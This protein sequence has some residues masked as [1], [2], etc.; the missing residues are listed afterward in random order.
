MKNLCN[1]L[2]MFLFFV[3]TVSAQSPQ[4]MNYQAVV[5]NTSGNPVANN[6][7]VKLRFTIHDGSDTGPSVFTETQSTTANQF[8]LVNVK[9]GA[10]GS[11]SGVNWG[12][13]S[14]FLEV[15]VE[16][17]N[18]GTFNSMGNSQLL[19]VPYA[20]YAANSNAGATGAQGP[21]GPQGDAG[22]TGLQGD[23]GPT[24]PTGPDGNPG[25]T[26]AE[27]PIG[28][29]GAGVTGPQGDV[30]ATGAEGP[31]GPIGNTGPAGDQGPTGLQGNTGAQGDAGPTGPTGAGGGA[32]GATGETGATG[33]TGNTGPQGLTGPT[34]AGNTGPTGPQ[35]ATG[36]A[37]SGTLSVFQSAVTAASSTT[38]TSASPVTKTSLALAAGTYIVTFSADINSSCSANCGTFVFDDGTTTFS[39]GSV[40]NNGGYLP[41]SH[42]AYVTYNAAATLNIK[43]YSFSASYTT[44]IRN[45][46]IIA[47]KVQ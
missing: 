4:L 7:P 13:G 42:T 47:V 23:A 38:N 33:P 11:L 46:R 12:N 31:T 40:G 20:L 36:A 41:I 1:T 32:T 8:G 37:G 3:V 43:F 29:T 5:R 45:A 9:V 21:T 22:A 44:Q 27:G 28:P 2:A 30:G 17:N 16:L 26:G 19:S 15:E 35:G 25:A 24:G 39:Q 10:V 14:K 34:G 6:T 18:S